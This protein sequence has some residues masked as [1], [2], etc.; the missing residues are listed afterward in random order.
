MPIKSEERL[1][2][3]HYLSLIAQGNH[4]AF[5]R[6]AKRY[7][8]HSSHLVNELLT[9]YP[10]TG[11]TR[12]ELLLVCDNH[13][14]FVIVKYNHL[15]GASLLTFW[16]ESTKNVA[17]DYLYDNSYQGGALS[18]RGIISFDEENDLSMSYSE[19][20][21]E[22][23]DARR[24]KKRIF[25][26]KTIIYQYKNQFTKQEFIILNLALNGFTFIDFE[27]TN[28]MSRTT[29]RLTFKSAVKK[30]TKLLKIGEEK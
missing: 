12:N 6:L 29:V 20:L 16:K 15:I 21:A 23:D 22:K 9:K 17:M 7:H 13:F 26:I 30:L 3:E 5:A 11:I 27:R 24:N 25:E 14:P 10:N 2:D 28:V 19:L 8:K 18:F 4:D 1:L